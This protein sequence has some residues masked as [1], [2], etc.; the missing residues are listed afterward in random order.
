MGYPNKLKRFAIFAISFWV[1]GVAFAT[2]YLPPAV[3]LERKSLRIIN[4]HGTVGLPKGQW[5]MFIQHRFGTFGDGAYNWYGFDQSYMRIGLDYGLSKRITTGLSRSSMNKIADAYVK[6]EMPL[7]SKS[8]TASWY[9]NVSLNT[10]H[11]AAISGEPF[12]YSNRLRFINTLNISKNFG[13]R[14]LLGITP[15]LVHVNLANTTSS[16]ND[17]PVMGGYSRLKLSN[18]YAI[19]AEVQRPMGE[20]FYN[21]IGGFKNT[22]RPASPYVGLGFEIFTA[23]HM[24]QLSVSNAQSMNETYYMVGENGGTGLKNFRFGFNI[25]RRW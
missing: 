25:V 6:W 10:N 12:Y 24:F 3:S 19:T 9:S 2:T 1:S 14:F 11:R 20:R 21:V 17:I 15:S 23:K 22:N 8:W 13:D 5:E 16:S 18:R 7:K 4:M